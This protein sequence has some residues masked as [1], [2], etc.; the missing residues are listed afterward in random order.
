[1]RRKGSQ[2]MEQVKVGLIGCAFSSYGHLHVRLPLERLDHRIDVPPARNSGHETAA[3]AM[4][5]AEVKPL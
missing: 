3:M 4:N 1:M 2:S 5:F